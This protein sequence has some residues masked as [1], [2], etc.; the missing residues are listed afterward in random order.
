MKRVDFEQLRSFMQNAQVP[1]VERVDLLRVDATH[2]LDTTHQLAMGQF[3]TPA[4]T[5]RLLASMFD[6]PRSSI[7]LLDAGAGV[8][9][10]S[11]AF[12]AQVCQAEKKPEYLSITAYEIDPNLTE[13]LGEAIDM[14]RVEC[15]RSGIQFTAEIVQEDFIETSV[16]M[17]ERSLLSPSLKEFDCAILNPPY[18][19]INS[20]SG[21]RQLLRKIGIETTNLYTAFLWLASYLLVPGGELVAITPR[22]FCNGSYFK[23]FRKAFLECMQFQQLHVFEA[24]NKAFKDDA[25]LQENIIFH[26]IKSKSNDSE[27]EIISSASSEDKVPS[28]RL[29]SHTQLVSPDDPNQY[30]PIVTDSLGQQVA[31][32]IIALS[33]TLKDLD[34]SVSTGRV[35]DFRATKFL[36]ADPSHDTVPLL[37]PGH[38]INRSITWPRPGYKKPNAIVACPESDSLLVPSGIYVLT[39]RFTAKEESRR[40]V[41]AVFHPDKYPYG[42]VGFENHLNYYHQNG[43]G[44]PE[45]LAWG[46]AA[47]LNS[48]LVDEY[49]RQFNGHTQVNS[50]DLRSLKYPSREQL[51]ILG[52]KCKSALMAQDKIDT[53]I[54]ELFNVSEE[55][56]GRDPIQ[57]TKRID[58]SLAIVK[59][60]GLPREQHN[61]RS[62][63]VLLAFLDLE[64]GQQWMNAKAPLQGITPIIEFI[65]EKYGRAYKP[66]SRE[67]IRDETVAAFVNAG[68]V[69]KNPDAPQ[70]APNSPKTVYQIEPAILALLQ[71]YGTEQWTANLR[72]WSLVTPLT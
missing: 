42:R 48:T 36:R 43:S 44:L 53:Y 31:K 49:F 33:W 30:I 27:V 68:I 62:A 32:R 17:L 21:H 47:F 22:S 28:V 71:T 55:A 56:E 24:R 3:L 67:T 37:Y 61:E 16:Y 58:E 2:R 11:A 18:R 23:N 25:V 50:G 34:V 46:L 19:K 7:R 29:I 70:R 66:N 69:I 9:S 64:V 45:R 13:Y 59:E 72:V 41:A 5:A 38:I 20:S 60:L 65:G 15:E 57:A 63:L 1:L 52:D 4:V 10:L 26:A 54:E 6:K 8:G 14:C 51:E 12:V 40:I 35:V 39:K